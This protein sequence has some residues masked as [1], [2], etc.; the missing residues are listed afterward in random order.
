V[1]ASKR[2]VAKKA[3]RASVK[4]PALQQAEDQLQCVID[5]AADFYWEQDAESR[6]TFYRPRAEPDEDLRN[7]VGKTSDELCAICPNNS[8]A[9]D[10]QRAAV[11]A[12]EV[13]RN[14]TYRI[15]GA[16]N[17]A[18]YFGFSGQPMPICAAS[19]P[20]QEMMKGARP[21]RFRTWKR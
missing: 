9:A 16:S 13:F 20:A 1:G 14:I 3:A 2:A 12:R 15:D 19:W 21:C 4:P 8:A 6:F 18:R 17:G 10:K 7:I 11:E 5:L